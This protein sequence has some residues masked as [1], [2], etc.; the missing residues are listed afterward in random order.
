MFRSI[1]LVL[2][3]SLAVTQALPSFSGLGKDPCSDRTRPAEGAVVVDKSDH[4]YP[5]SYS[6]VQAAVDALNSTT[7]TP[8]TLFIFP[9]T[10]V[11]QV[12]I[13]QLASNLTIQ[14]YTSNG[15]SY[16]GN[17]A[18]ITYDLALI[19]S[20]DDDMTA[21]LRMWNP[22]TKVYNLNIVNTFGHI[23][24]NGQNLAVSAHTTGQGYYGC[25]LIGYQDT[26]NA[27]Y[28]KKPCVRGRRPPE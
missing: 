15:E 17:K 21:T 19:D 27:E 3:A 8:Q 2:A 9:G 7:T 5:G 22:N 10:Y 16:E 14:G 11:E 4:P 26:L 28:G 24:E 25:Q 13:R 12:Y 18:T 1:R 23:P 20:T 6:T